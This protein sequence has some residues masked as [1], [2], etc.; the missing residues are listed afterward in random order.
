MTK[1]RVVVFDDDP[2]VLSLVSAVL[3]LSGHEVRTYTDPRPFCKANG[4]GSCPRSRDERCAD[5]VL[6]DVH[7]PNLGGIEFLEAQRQKGCKCPR[8]ALMSGAWTT[9]DMERATRLGAK[10]F[11]KPFHF[12]QIRSWLEEASN[13]TP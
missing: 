10:C 8:I 1:L 9:T 13:S 4:K 7:M 2:L 3:S 11:A 12:E 6:C 5:V